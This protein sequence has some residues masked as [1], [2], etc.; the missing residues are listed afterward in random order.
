MTDSQP[1]RDIRKGALLRVGLGLPLIGLIIILPAWK[2]DY[3]QGWL[4]MF[5]LFFPMIFVLSYLLK[6]TLLYWSAA[7]ARAKKRQHNGGSSG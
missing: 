2:W 1:T 3:W 7:C 6:T 4:Y 5:I